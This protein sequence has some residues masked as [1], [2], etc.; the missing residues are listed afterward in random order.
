[1]QQHVDC[2][3]QEMRGGG[4]TRSS[5]RMERLVRYREEGDGGAGMLEAVVRGE[6]GWK[7]H[8]RRG[9]GRE[10]NSDSPFQQ[11]WRLLESILAH[12]CRLVSALLREG[13]SSSLA[14]FF[15]LCCTMLVL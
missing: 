13:S 10:Y 6:R 12:V 3:V 7:A 4:S 2:S 1:V 8:E 11:R 15:S 5:C 9:L 14:P